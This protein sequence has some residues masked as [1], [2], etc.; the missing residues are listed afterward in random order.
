[1]SNAQP[2]S[3]RKVTP[4]QEV[5]CSPGL[6]FNL[7]FMLRRRSI[8]AF[9][10]LLTSGGVAACSDV[11]MEEVPL[12]VC[13]SGKRWIG[14]DRGSPNMYPGRD[15]V[16]CHKENDAP[17]LILGGTMYDVLDT[18][19]TQSTDCFGAEGV[20]ITITGGDD[21]V[22]ETTTNEA[23]NFWFAAQ[24]VELILPFKARFEYE[25]GVSGGVDTRNMGT[26]P[27]YGGCA[28][29]HGPNAVPTGEGVDPQSAE[30]VPPI[31]ANIGRI[32]SA[33]TGGVEGYIEWVNAGKPAPTVTQE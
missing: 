16:G 6:C 22:F 11:V 21:Q 10:L 1:M 30:Y 17:E 14:G 5:L 18:D 12:E 7:R 32:G 31:A 20:K 13:V 27:Y 29:C 23:G 2:Q 8:L 33:A 25:N 26:L 24:E 15:C 3:R 4:P 19:Y 9:A 28:R